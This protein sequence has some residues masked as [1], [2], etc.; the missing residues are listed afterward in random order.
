[1]VHEHDVEGPVLAYLA[2][3]I[4]IAMMLAA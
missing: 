1:M 3:A 2:M 4:A